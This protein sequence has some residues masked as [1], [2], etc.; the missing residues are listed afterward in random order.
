MNLVTNHRETTKSKPPGARIDNEIAK[1]DYK[2]VS[3]ISSSPPDQMF[4]FGG[5]LGA[6]KGEGW[7]TSCLEVARDLKPNGE[8]KMWPEKRGKL[9]FFVVNRSSAGHEGW[10]TQNLIVW[11]SFTYQ[12]CLY[13]VSLKMSLNLLLFVIWY[14][15]SSV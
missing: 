5:P 10:L 13:K 11:Y 2:R 9:H 15:L 8:E 7:P 1:F 4:T 14:Y 12:L 6:R 3:R